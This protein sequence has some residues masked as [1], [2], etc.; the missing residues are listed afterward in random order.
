MART[1]S[2]AAAS[3]TRW[4]TSAGREERRAGG[5]FPSRTAVIRARITAL[6]RSCYRVTRKRLLRLFQRLSPAALVSFGGRRARNACTGVGVRAGGAAPRCA[7]CKRI[8]CLGGGSDVGQALAPCAGV[9]RV[10]D[11]TTSAGG[12]RRW[13]DAYRAVDGRRGVGGVATLPIFVA[14]CLDVAAYLL[15][16][17]WASFAFFTS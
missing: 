5:R 8:V 3:A 15:P 6:W 16:Q 7:L 14:R 9:L 1:G 17:G 11:M 4:A 13:N 2:S 12:R 10:T